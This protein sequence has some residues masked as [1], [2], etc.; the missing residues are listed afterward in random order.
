MTPEPPE[1]ELVIAENDYNRLEDTDDLYGNGLPY[2]IVF[3]EFGNIYR[4]LNIDG[5]GPA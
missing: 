5:P 2:D 4:P 3:D 1:V